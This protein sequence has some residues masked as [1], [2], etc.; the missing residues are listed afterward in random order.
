MPDAERRSREQKSRQWVID[1]FSVEVI[2]A[3]LEQIIDKMPPVNYDYELQAAPLNP[4][5]EPK[6]NYANKEEFLIDIY[7]NILNDKVDKNT[8]GFKH[9]MAQLN[10]GADPNGIVN[11]FKQVAIN[12]ETQ[13]N[14]PDLKDLLDNDDEGRRLGVVIPEGE[15][16][17]FSNKFFNKKP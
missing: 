5:Y 2:G 3:Q 8:Q 10:A 11:H 17:V 4:D 9:W 6:K 15:N 16:D 1:N 12:L 7:E 14:A 13:K